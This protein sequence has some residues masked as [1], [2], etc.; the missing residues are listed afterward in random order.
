MQSKINAA[1]LH[2][3]SFDLNKTFPHDVS[4]KQSNLLPKQ[5]AI[6]KKTI[7]K[8]SALALCAIVGMTVFMVGCSKEDVTDPNGAMSADAALSRNAAPAPGVDPIAGIAVSAGFSELVSALVYVDN[9]LNTG[10]VDLFTNG[11]D[12]YTVFAP[13]NAAFQSLYTALNVNGIT[14]LPATLVRD[15]LL[16]HVVDGRRAANSVVPRTGNRTITTLLGADFS[17]NTQG[18]ITAIG[19]TANITSANISASNGIIHVIDAVILPV[20]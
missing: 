13:T 20:Q 5:K 19:N 2:F 4:I 1:E 10:L 6:M 8:S 7:F 18:Q 12:Q 9:S 14:D 11:K 17:V 15:V 16:Y 3:F